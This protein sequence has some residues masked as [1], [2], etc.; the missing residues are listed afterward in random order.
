MLFHST[1]GNCPHQ[2][3]CSTT[4]ISLPVWAIKL[5]FLHRTSWDFGSTRRQQA[6][7]LC[8]ELQREPI[9]WSFTSFCEIQKLSLVPYSAE[10]LEPFLFWQHVPYGQFSCYRQ[11]WRKKLPRI[12]DNLIFDRRVNGNSQK[13][14]RKII[15]PAGFTHGY[16]RHRSRAFPPYLSQFSWTS[17]TSH[18]RLPYRWAI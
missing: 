14:D 11:I 2:Q 16:T 8:L 7:W 1:L 18:R 12:C 4:N 5:Q 17:S 13:K 10:V 3:M 15:L 9:G 6:H